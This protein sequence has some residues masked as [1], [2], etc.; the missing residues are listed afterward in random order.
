MRDEDKL[1]SELYGEGRYGRKDCKQMKSV[2]DIMTLD[3]KSIVDVGCG[4]GWLRNKVKHAGYLGIDIA[5]I[6]I[7]RSAEWAT[8][9]RFL[10]LDLRKPQTVPQ[11]DVAIC[12]DL[13]EHIDEPAVDAVIKNTL[14]CGK[15]VVLG[16]ALSPHVFQKNVLHVTVKSVDWWRNKIEEHTKI[17]HEIVLDRYVLFFISVRDE[18]KLYSDLYKGSYGRSG[19]KAFEKVLNIMTLTDKSIVDVGCG[20][21]W[22]RNKIRHAGYTGIDIASIFT[23]RSKKWAPNEKFLH[24]D[25]R[26]PQ[27]V[28]QADIAICMD[29]LEHI[30]E[31]TVDL[32]IKNTLKWGKEVVFSISCRTAYIPSGDEINLHKTVKPADW[33][34]SKIKKHAKIAH[35]IVSETSVLFF[36]SDRDLKIQFTIPYSFQDMRIKRNRLTG[37]YSIA[38]KHR[39]CEKFLDG[40]GIRVPNTLQWYLPYDGP[41]LGLTKMCYIV[42]KGPSLDAIKASHFDGVSSVLCVNDS[43]HKIVSLGIKNPLFLVQLDEGFKDGNIVP[44]VTSILNP[45]VRPFI[46]DRPNVYYIYPRTLGPTAHTITAVFALNFAQK[47]GVRDFKFVCFDACVVKKLGYAKC[48]G[49]DSKKGGKTNRFLNHR[50]R[51]DDAQ[52][53]SK[54]EWIIPSQQSVTSSEKVRV[55]ID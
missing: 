37:S 28:P 21:G 10:H 25:L 7:E 8:N 19:C 50:K 31:T 30:D 11:S 5:S 32:V 18:D 53:D 15:E 22:L 23:E 51:I 29:L 6:F 48:I 20:T 41:K 33:W 26:K 14:K 38:R 24:M 40:I 34:R 27:N 16:I 12:L 1:Y 4:T 35:E 54:I 2:L 45:K 9:E 3:D 46:G 52:G 55:S 36:I 44:G 42:G 39:A 47:M 17:D 43:I 13:L 49:Y